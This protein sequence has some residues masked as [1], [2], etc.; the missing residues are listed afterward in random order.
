MQTNTHIR[1][2]AVALLVGVTTLLSLCIS[3]AASQAQ[4]PEYPVDTYVHIVNQFGKPAA[5]ANL[6][7]LNPFG[8]GGDVSSTSDRTGVVN[9]AGKPGSSFSMDATGGYLPIAQQMSDPYCTSEALAAWTPASVSGVVSADES[10]NHFTLQLNPMVRELTEPGI[11]SQE[12]RMLDLINAERAK[13]GRGPIRIFERAS[14]ASDAHATALSVTPG[15]G[16]HKGPACAD[17]PAYYAELGGSLA[18]TVD[19]MEQTVTYAESCNAGYDA[20]KAFAR[21]MGSPAHR[22]ALMNPNAVGAG[23]ARV[24]DAWVVD[25][26]GTSYGSSGNYSSENI[27]YTP[28]L[29]SLKRVSPNKWCG[30]GGDETD[31]SGDDSQDQGTVQ[32]LTVQQVK[33]AVKRGGKVTLKG[34]AQAGSSIRIR[35]GAKTATATAKSSDTWTKTVKLPKRIKGKTM[36]VTVTD[37]Q[38]TAKVTLRIKRR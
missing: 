35:Y 13:N 18:D 5:Y 21:Y 32:Q 1:G 25:L 3:P 23:I 8:D 14:A 27:A 29:A 7:V 33:K 20:D 31:P 12:Q 24:D 4:N 2:A 11:S 36:R 28:N 16:A 17:F 22:S 37:G 10:K 9:S 6:R 38:S 34:R 19:W 30:G 15:L 26:I